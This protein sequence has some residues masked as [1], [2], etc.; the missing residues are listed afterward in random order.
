[1]ISVIVGIDYIPH[2]E[3]QAVF[4]ELF[5]R[6]RFIRIEEGIYQDDSLFG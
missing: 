1:V 6:Q 2:L 4:E 3:T 5:D